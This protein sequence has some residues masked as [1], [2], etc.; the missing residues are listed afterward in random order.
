MGAPARRG[1]RWAWTAARP[2]LVGLDEVGGGEQALEWALHEA[3]VREAPVEVVTVWSWNERLSGPSP[4]LRPARSTARP[5][6]L[7]RQTQETVVARVLAGFGRPAPDVTVELAEGDPASRLIERSARAALLVLGG[8]SQPDRP[9]EHPASVAE[10][11]SR[12]AGCPV[13]VVPPR[14]A[15]AEPA[16]GRPAPALPEPARRPAAA[17]RFGPVQELPIPG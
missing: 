10:V 8:G 1:G 6:G 4:A 15:P 11:C 16:R 3:L 2:V 17:F 13:V 9:G 5:A 7:A 12:Y 14:P